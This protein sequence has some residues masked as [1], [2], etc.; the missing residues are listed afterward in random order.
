MRKSTSYGSFWR[1]TAL[2]FTPIEENKIKNV[3][4]ISSWGVCIRFKVLIILVLLRGR[5]QNDDKLTN[6][7]LY[8]P[9]VDFIKN[10]LKKIN[11][12]FYFFLA[13]HVFSYSTHHKG[14]RS[15]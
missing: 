4:Q 14:S 6:A 12:M 13:K 8:P 9:H 11:F 3:F 5:A 1:L 2:W 7:K 10:S 15:E